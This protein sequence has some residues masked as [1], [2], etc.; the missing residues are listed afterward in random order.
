MPLLRDL[1]LVGN[2]ARSKLRIPL[3]L[4]DHCKQVSRGSAIFFLRRQKVAAHKLG[5]R[6]IPPSLKFVDIVNMA[7]LSPEEFRKNLFQTFR[8]RGVLEALKVS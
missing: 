7:E 2:F 5:T 4:R 1:G 6:A 8:S 3:M